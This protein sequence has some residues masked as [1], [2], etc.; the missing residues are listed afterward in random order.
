MHL[1]KTFLLVLFCSYSLLQAQDK[2]VVQ[3]AKDNFFVVHEVT[4][5]ESLSSIGRIYGFTAKQLAQYND[6]NV[7]AVLALGTKLKVQLTPDNFSGQ[8]NL[9][10]SI[11]LYHISKRGD[12]LY[13]LSQLYNKVP[14]A[15]LRKWNDL[16]SD[17]VRDGQAIIIGFINGPKT[18]SASKAFADPT[19]QTATAKPIK[20]EPP[21]L[22]NYNVLD[23]RID[24]SRELKGE[25]KPLTDNELLLYAASQEKIRKEYA[26]NAG[27]TF[28]Q[29]PSDEAILS[30]DEIKYI[31]QPTDEGYFEMFFPKTNITSEK[32]SKT[33]EAATFNSTSGITDRK[34]YILVNNI[35]PGTIVRITASNKKAICARVLGPIPELANSEGL[36]LYMSNSAAAALN[37]K[38]VGFLV[39][40]VCYPK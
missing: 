7:N 30:D 11:A 10:T 28:K 38:E 6:I 16:S 40:L 26:L 36:L 22:K 23:A 34:F 33:G 31:P 25:L 2:L 32:Q 8:A 35:L 29:A 1:R 12:N 13:Q 19:A 17:N 9:E 14:V 4:E 20:A 39:N 18:Q 15:T 24:G 37:M 27:S 5:K 21:P 3:G